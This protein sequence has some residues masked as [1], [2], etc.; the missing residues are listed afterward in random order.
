MLP[1]APAS[2]VWR[3]QKGGAGWVALMRLPAASNATKPQID[4]HVWAPYRNE[5][6]LIK[7]LFTAR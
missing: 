5:P 7:E 1:K 6:E 4:L 2:A 3:V